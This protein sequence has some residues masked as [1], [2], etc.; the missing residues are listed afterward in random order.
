MN[1]DAVRMRDGPPVVELVTRAAGGDQ[2]AWNALVDRYAPLVW[3]ICRRYQLDNADAREVSQAVWRQLAGQLGTLR[4]PAA[5]GRWLATATQR[6][7][8]RFRRAAPG[9]GQTPGERTRITE[10]ELLVADRHAA[11]REAFAHLPPHCRRLIA[12]LMQDP[13]VPEAEI[14][15]KLGIP[16]RTLSQNCRSC[17]QQLRR[18]PAMATLIHAETKRDEPSAA[19]RAEVDLPADAVPIGDRAEGVTPE[20]LG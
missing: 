7:C 6:E 15:A 8:D 10:H 14:S 3:S 12:M 4:N 18:Y 19:C 13:P 1:S 2:Q 9:P 16:V 11:L 17:L 20:L 5:L